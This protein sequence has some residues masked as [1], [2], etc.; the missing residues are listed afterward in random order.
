MIQ[1]FMQAFNLGFGGT[2]G[3]RMLGDRRRSPPKACMG[4]SAP[5][6]RGRDA[7]RA[8]CA[9]R[10]LSQRS[11]TVQ[12]APLSRIAPVPNSA[13]MCR[14]GRLPAG[15]ASA[16]DQKQGQA[17]SQVPVDHINQYR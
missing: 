2:H 7:V 14:S 12:P 16:M 9:S 10:S 5:D 15:A 11:F 6:A 8:T 13:S 4:C 1:S 3:T 17:R